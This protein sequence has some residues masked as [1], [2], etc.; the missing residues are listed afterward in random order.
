MVSITSSTSTDQ[1]GSSH[2]T[3]QYLRHSYH[4]SLDIDTMI[5]GIC[6]FHFW[7][8]VLSIQIVRTQTIFNFIT[9]RYTIINKMNKNSK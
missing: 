6:L 1:L 4:L 2:A 3:L 7:M 5:F 9:H 8:L